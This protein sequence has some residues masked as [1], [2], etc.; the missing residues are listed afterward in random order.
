[1][2][3]FFS[4]FFLIIF[5]FIQLK[6]QLIIQI[7]T[8]NAP[9]NVNSEEFPKLS[10]QIRAIYNGQPVKLNKDDVKILESGL[11]FTSKV[12]EISDFENGWQTIKWIPEL[13][14][15]DSFYVCRIYILYEN[16][17][18]STIGYGMLSRVPYTMVTNQD[19]IQIREV[20]WENVQ[21]GNNIPFQV[22]FRGQINTS[23]ND[24][25]Y[26]IYLDSITTTTPY[27]TIKWIGSD[28][29]FDRSPPPRSIRV[30]SYYWV[31]IYFAPTE[32]KYYQDMLVFHFEGGLKRYIPLYGNSFTVN[33]KS[34]IQLVSPNGGEVFSPCQEVEIKWRGY[35]PQFPTEIFYSSNGG[36]T[37]NFIA[38]VNDSIYNWR[39]PDIE[40]DN[41][42][43]KVRQNFNQNNQYL[44]GED[45]RPV[46]AA[47]FNQ[48]STILSA[49][50]ERGKILTYSLNSLPPKL[51]RKQYLGKSDESE[52]FNIYGLA[53]SPL[54][55]LI[56]VGYSSA[57]LPISQRFDS[58]AVFNSSSDIPVKKY[59]APN[60]IKINKIKT[61]N[62][63]QYIAILPS[64]GNMV[65]LY[66][67]KDFSLIKTIYFDAQVLDFAFNTE[68]NQA[69]ALLLDGEVRLIDL[70]KFE[71]F[72]KLSFNNFP[73]FVQ[74]ALSPNGKLLSLGSKADRTGL[75]T[76]SYVIDI[77]TEQIVRVFS[78]SMGDPIGMF[79]NPSSS[80]L[81]VGST[82]DKQ[83]AFYDLTTSN[84]TGNL[85]GH[86]DLMTDIQLAP[87][88]QSLVSTAN[89]N[90]NFV[91][92]TFVYP[93]EDISDNYSIIN[94]PKLNLD[95]IF[96]GTYY[97]G[98]QNQ[99][100][101]KSICNQSSVSADFTTGK[102]KI[103]NNFKLV[104][105]WIPTKLSPNDCFDIKI[106]FNPIDT[107]IVI[108]T[109][110]I[111]SCNT[112]YKIP[113][114]AKVL[115]RNITYLSNNFNFGE[116]CIG[117]TITKELEILRNEDPVP[118]IVNYY[119]FENPYNKNFLVF[120]SKRDTIVPPGG[121]L[122]S[123][124]RFILDT[125]GNYKG[126]ITI[127][128]SNQ[129]KVKGETTVIGKGIGSFI[130]LSH[131]KLLFIPEILKRELE[132]TNIGT[133]D[134]NFE[135]FIVS[136]PNNFRVTT[137]TPF[138]LKS[139]EKKIIEI[140]WDGQQKDATLVINAVPCLVQKFIPLSFYKGNAEIIIPK[141]ETSAKNENVEIPIQINIIQK[142]A[143]KGSRI[144]EATFI[145]NPKIFLPIDITSTLGQAK[146]TS[147]Y[148]NFDKR[149]FKIS[150]IGNFDESGILATIKGVA[151]LTDTNYSDL[152]IDKNSLLFGKNVDAIVRNGG[153][154]INDI[155]NDRYIKNE[156]ANIQI[157]NLSPNPAQDYINIEFEAKNEQ[158]IKIEM[159]NS[160]GEK[161]F[162]IN[163]YFPKIGLNTIKINLLEYSNGNYHI[164]IYE[165]NKIHFTNFII[166]R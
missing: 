75:K 79:F 30:G 103:N 48:Y 85:F 97:L 66:N 101:I 76:N 44:L 54:D 125:L 148:I 82:S 100:D 47:G 90:D 64:F 159:Y 28:S 130:S 74:I 10:A 62:T 164:K 114:E 57:D 93:E 43:I 156:K 69:A 81:I 108:D 38:S 23:N 91:Y 121:I 155:C 157:K 163:N 8:I 112:D 50:N 92:R 138:V 104:E 107:G 118:L 98:T 102:F 142:E 158:P 37:W 36:F 63:K 16:N 151:G 53:Y 95:K 34:L 106:Q 49:I 161:L 46:L 84:N 2:K 22:R 166:L 45:T 94:K 137:A 70:N 146:L 131:E 124:V 144:F 80:T 128:H 32:N 41:L 126:I 149:E 6:S 55:S 11:T 122:S 26:S 105:N 7:K 123:K 78:P 162:H 71:V 88:G 119:I 60:N 99:I 150:I 12:S 73:N 120:I 59:P 134:I 96:I 89:S 58:I 152:I 42:L 77:S 67:S 21:P 52:Y 87:N 117:D 154:F 143:Y 72:K 51:V 68:I 86:Y 14:T 4:F 141:I 31:N 109:L 160:L 56:Y 65:Y 140:E 139:N 133:S 153:I 145:T 116:I 83:I 39:V 24:G 1:M 165:H 3:Y 13:I 35:A 27:F 61:D 20:F 17:L 132:I 40:N 135:S 129:T 136:P 29:D 111:R 33:S 110:I 19:N 25:P 147:N 18:A 115:P 15:F 9:F 127:Y 5:S 113:F